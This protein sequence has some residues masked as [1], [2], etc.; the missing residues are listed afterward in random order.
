MAGHS[1]WAQ[2]KRKKGARDAARGKL[3]TKLIRE[4]TVAAREGGGD[5]DGNARLRLAVQ[6]AKDH[7]MPQDNIARAIKK[8][9]GDLDGAHYEEVT[10][11]GYGPSG[12]A[13]MIE[14]LTDNK[15]RTAGEVRHV[16][17]KHS[18]NLGSSGC[19]SW[20]FDKKGIIWVPKGKVEEERLIEV[21]VEAGAE[22]V[23]DEGDGFEVVT[24]LA[25]FE[26][27]RHAI[28]EAGID[29]QS[30][31]LQNIPSNQVKVDG[32]EARKVVR[33]MEA[34]EDLDDVQQVSANF[35][36]PSDILQED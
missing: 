30:A 34:L 20:I 1:K 23:T 3:F 10:Y 6:T 32:D 16:L 18:G 35:D 22:D 15:N 13:L 8:G 24:G 29:Y 4:I 7:N 19:V 25:E 27:V 28:Q 17:T 5:P 31:E 33:L 2:I 26:P 21:A 12:V 36:I 9:T 14:T 11:E